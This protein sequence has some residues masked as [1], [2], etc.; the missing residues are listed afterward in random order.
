ML[1]KNVLGRGTAAREQRCLREWCTELGKL[2]PVRYELVHHDAV[3]L[4][5]KLPSQLDFM[6]SLH[7][8]MLRSLT[9]RSISCCFRVP[10]PPSALVMSMLCLLPWLEQRPLNVREVRGR[11]I[12]K[13]EV[14][15]VDQLLVWNG[16]YTTIVNID[17]TVAITV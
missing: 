16:E 15:C 5:A 12:D 9:D 17:H 3:A 6:Q 4:V 14:V 10:E 2:T 1:R 11:G 7:R 8:P 13:I